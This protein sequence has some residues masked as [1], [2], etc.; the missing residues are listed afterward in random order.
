MGF[1]KFCRCLLTRHHGNAGG[2]TDH[3][4]QRRQGLRQQRG[5]A[6]QRGFRQG[7]RQKVGIG[8][9]KLLV[10]QIDDHRL[11]AG[12]RGRMQ[13]L[14]QQQWRSQVGVHVG[15]QLCSRKSLGG[16]VFEQ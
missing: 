14:R 2:H 9:V 3:P 1:F 6:Q 10:Q 7:V 12:R 15:V 8:I 11:A 4:H 16:I 5:G 13:R